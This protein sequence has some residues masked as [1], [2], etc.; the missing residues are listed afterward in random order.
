MEKGLFQLRVSTA[1]VPSCLAL[2]SLCQGTASWQRCQEENLLSSGHS[3]V[4]EVPGG[5]PALL[6][7]SRK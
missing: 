6:R 1:S 7:A 4:A 5:E 3:I 2:L